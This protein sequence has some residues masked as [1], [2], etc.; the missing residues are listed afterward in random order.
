MYW[1]IYMYEY[2]L[3]TR[4]DFCMKHGVVSSIIL[5]SGAVFFYSRACGSGLTSSP[6]LTH[7]RI[8]FLP[9][10]LPACLPA[11]F[12]FW[13]AAADELYPVQD[14]IDHRD[15]YQDEIPRQSR[16]HLRRAVLPYHRH[17]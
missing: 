13:P 4:T 6:E 16:V 1:Y 17:I 2:V 14:S 5:L 10:G 8:S 3:C 15:R 12:L 9:S 7:C 11:F